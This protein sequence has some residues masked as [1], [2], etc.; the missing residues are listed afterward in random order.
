MILSYIIHDVSQGAHEIDS[1]QA[2]HH[3]VDANLNAAEDIRIDF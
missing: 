1:A 2:V 3:T